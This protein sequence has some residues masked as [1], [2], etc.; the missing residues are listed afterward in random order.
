MCLGQR[1]TELDGLRKE[2]YIKFF[3]YIEAYVMKTV[4]SFV[5]EFLL[6]Y[7]LFISR[8]TCMKF[9]TF[10]EALRNIALNFFTRFYLRLN[11]KLENDSVQ[12]NRNQKAYKAQNFI[13]L[14]KQNYSCRIITC[15]LIIPWRAVVTFMFCWVFFSLLK[16]RP[17]GKSKHDFNCALSK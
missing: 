10:C 4:T 6:Y 9:T 14:F 13:E 7:I 3:V 8:D 12:W 5:H 15:R 1:K 11:V 16:K 17:R 2:P